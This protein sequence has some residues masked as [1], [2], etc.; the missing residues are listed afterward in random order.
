MSEENV[1]LARQAMDAWDRRDRAAW[2][3]LHDQEHEVVPDR[4]FPEAGAI[5]GREPAWE[6]FVNIFGAFKQVPIAGVE[7]MDAG[8]DRVLIHYRLDVRG[9]ASGAEVEVDYWD[10]VTF[11][12]G[13]IV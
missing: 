8:V 1:K 11:R 5:R 3:A 6:F 12:E 2:L 7:I 4:Y 10:V 13:R 9:R